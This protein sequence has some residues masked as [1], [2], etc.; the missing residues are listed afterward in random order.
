MLLRKGRFRE[1][2][3]IMNAVERSYDSH[4]KKC[5]ILRFLIVQAPQIGEVNLD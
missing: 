2:L 5:Q 3:G 1:I 4:V